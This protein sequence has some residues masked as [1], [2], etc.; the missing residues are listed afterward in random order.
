M[1]GRVLYRFLIPLFLTA[2]PQDFFLL[3]HKVNY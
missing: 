3:L 2:F 1:L